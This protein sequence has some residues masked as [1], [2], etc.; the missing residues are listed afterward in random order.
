MRLTST[1]F[2]SVYNDLSFTPTQEQLLAM[3]AS[4]GLP[5]WF[6]IGVIGTTENEGYFDEEYLLY[7]WACTF[8]N[9]W[10]EN[11]YPAICASEQAMY[12]IMAGWGAG[13]SYERIHEKYN[14]ATEDTLKCVYLAFVDRDRNTRA[15]S[16]DYYDES[17]Y[18]YFTSSIYLVD[19]QWISVWYVTGADIIDDSDWFEFT[20]R[21]TSPEGENNPCY[22]T[23]G[24]DIGLGNFDSTHWNT[25]MQGSPVVI[26]ATALA[27]CTGYAEG[28]SLEI[29]CEATGFDPIENN[30]HP[31]LIFS[32]HNAGEW[33]DV[34]DN[35]QDF[36][37]NPTTPSAGAI[38]VWTQSGNAGHV[39]IVE[40]V[41]DNDTVI[42]TESGYDGIAGRTWL[43]HTRRR[44]QNGLWDGDL[45]TMG[46]Y[47]FLGFIANLGGF[48]PIPPEPPEP[49]VPPTSKKSK[50]WMYMKKRGVMFI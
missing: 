33:Y 45:F 28:R 32:S 38:M 2:P 26:G 1:T 31:W 5:E 49:P 19:N 43:S 7:E 50:W 35:S 34:A 15:V 9:Y 14:N 44:G 41:I 27:N 40:E 21:N 22:M 48:S 12:N 47:Q 17:W 16:G 46:G 24:S 6:M 42:T 3:G 18:A 39:A 4:K 13:Y 11:Y 30:G 37:V 29:Y 8:L 23:T 25:C 20:V 36:S 10:L